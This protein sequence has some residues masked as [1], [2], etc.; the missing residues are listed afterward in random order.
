MRTG[1]SADVQHGVKAVVVDQLVKAVMAASDLAEFGRECWQTTV[2]EAAE[3]PGSPVNHR[4]Q[5][6][7]QKL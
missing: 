7:Q 4:R 2:P 1:S 3:Q 5:E 6:G